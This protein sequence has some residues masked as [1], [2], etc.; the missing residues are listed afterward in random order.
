[1]KPSDTSSLPPAI[2]LMGPTASG[3]TAA[4]MALADALPVELISVDSAQVFRDMNVGTAKPS[5]KLRQQYPHALIDIISPEERYSAARFCEDAQKAMGMGF[6]D[7]YHPDMKNHE[8]YEELY[9][10]YASIGKFTEENLF[11][12]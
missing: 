8:A 3:K 2:L 9:E 5:P 12:K 6:S 10:Q 7:E 4:A 11:N 1:M